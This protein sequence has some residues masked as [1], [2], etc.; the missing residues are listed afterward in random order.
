MPDGA[1][2]NQ[3]PSFHASL[4]GDEVNDLARR[5]LQGR[6]GAGTVPSIRR[7]RFTNDELGL[8]LGGGEGAWE[9]EVAP[10][11]CSVLLS[12]REEVRG[13]S[14]AVDSPQLSL[15]SQTRSSGGVG[16]GGLSSL[17]TRGSGQR[18]WSRDGKR[19]MRAQ[20]VV[21]GEIASGVRSSSLTSEDADIA[22]PTAS[23][24]D[25][26]AVGWMFFSFL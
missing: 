7:H 19:R 10:T 23:C 3:N 11:A 17:G 21:R 22:R 5:C 1:R 24:W 4:G 12:R 25:T 8:L 15:I 6:E 16:A 26:E 14:T 20:E 2:L 9:L 13:G 18:P